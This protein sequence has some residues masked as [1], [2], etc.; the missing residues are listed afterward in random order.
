MS[1]KIP[2][3]L[4]RQVAI[5]ANYRCEYCRRP[6]VDSFIR[7]QSDHIIS[8]KHG[9]K[10]ELENL[11]HTC[12]TCNNA[13]GSDIAT[14]LENENELIRFFNPRRD[15]WDDHF[16]VSI[17]GEIN[18]KTEIATATIKILKLNEINRILERVDLIEA[19]LFP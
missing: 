11:A 14:I 9:G 19:G 15:T 8:R 1:K 3:I 16:E 10:T 5:R 17:Q 13:K 12:P 18:P 4:R 7:Y 6:E 2:D